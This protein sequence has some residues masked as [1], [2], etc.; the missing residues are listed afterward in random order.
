MLPIRCIVPR[1]V[2]RCGLHA[3]T[4]GGMEFPGAFSGLMLAA[5]AGLWMLYLVPSW[6]RRR[7]Y[8]ATER[9]AVRLQQT[10]RVL[11]ETAEVP[12]EVRA[13]ATAKSVAE[14]Q[15]IVRA[16]LQKAEA[17]A[18]ARDA[19][20]AREAARRLAKLEPV[21]TAID[22][23]KLRA[24]KRLRRTRAVTALLLFGS[25]GVAGTQVALLATAGASWLVLGASVGM[26]SLSTAM[27][28]RLAKVR[29][30][31]IRVEAQLQQRSAP[32]RV[33]QR[34][35][36]RQQ[37]REWTPVPLPKPLYLGRPDM[38]KV[39]RFDPS[40]ELREAAER[41]AAAI[42]EAEKEPEVTPFKRPEKSGYA[43]MGIVD[44]EVRP[45]DLDAVL[46]RRRAAG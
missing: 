29:R 37:T 43:A 7:E 12:V 14:Q 9:N 8:L 33:A 16:E 27:L 18:R 35:P 38:Q 41:A 15:R 1:V 36:Q 21:V 34:Q 5:A 2:C 20:A 6:L 30:P 46:R 28:A 39:V 4:L 25:L 31:R 23:S 22:D 11:A 42:R 44:V 32:Q 3:R 40:A 24:V 13:E 10:L 45:T 19:A 17:I 26:A